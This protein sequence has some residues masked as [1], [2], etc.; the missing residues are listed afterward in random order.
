MSTHK[1]KAKCPRCGS[2]NLLI[3]ETY[4][5]SV[6]FKQSKGYIQKNYGISEYGNVIRLEALCEQ[7]GHEWKF[8]NAYQIIGIL[9]Q[10]DNF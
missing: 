3:K 1:S 9:E 4:E 7:C 8:R 10:P 2:I 5:A 6:T